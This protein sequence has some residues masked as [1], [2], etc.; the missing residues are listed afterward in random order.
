VSPTLWSWF[1]RSAERHANAP[2]LEVG[3]ERLTYG[4][5]DELAA[6]AASAVSAAAGGRARAVG[7]R[8]SRSV[9]A[10]A[11]YLGALR[12]GAAVVPLSPALPV[13]RSLAMCRAAGV[14][15]VV[16]DDAGAAEPLDE[17]V[18]L[19]RLTGTSWRS[20]P[21][22]APAPPP[23][24]A[25][26]DD[27]AYV[28]FTS[29][30]T[31][32]PKGVPI[33]HRQLAEYLAFSI[34]RYR[35]GPGCRLSQTF[36]LSFDPSVFDLFVAWGAGAT[37]V[38]PRPEEVLTPARFV[39]G[40]GISHWF[41]VPSVIPLARRLRGLPPGAMP[42]L[43]W[44]LFAGEP[45]TL[46]QAAAWAAAAPA[47]VVEN[48]YGPTEL[49]ITCT[50]YRLPRA[51]DRWPGT[52]NGTVPIGRPLPHLE[53]VVLTG[54]G[55]PGVEGELCVRGPQ[56]FDGYLHRADDDGRFLRLREGI[57]APAPP[58]R[59]SDDWYRTGDR[60]RWEDGELV[61]LGRTD[62]QVKVGGYRVEPAEVECVLREH[63]GADEVVV[64]A[65]DAGAGR[66]EL[67]GFYTGPGS[68]RE[69]LRHARRRLP[70][71]LVPARLLHLSELP[72]NPNG[73]VD[74]N[75]L[76]Q[77]GAQPDPLGADPL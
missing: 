7:L 47:A 21:A 8:C 13:A 49:T 23:D 26:P 17:A 61:H 72:L 63:A 54:E 2:A 58:P 38:V 27:V 60:V 16:A 62:D 1:A 39:T 30:T 3:G 42:G 29:G 55:A 36:E 75:R 5:L 20:R 37:V 66:A 11:G 56:R 50:A 46:D 43:R 24:P 31:A 40:R 59:T 69:I 71:Y 32:R 33:R 68:E 73:K 6:R 22:E 53:G 15:V 44:G 67:R 77:L 18:P 19:V 51:S 14:A 34:D 70:S 41:S 28:L 65:V 76:R 57:G 74:R 52:V 64:L 9:A 35:V 48:L 10:Y 4:E 25:G 45:L 12:A